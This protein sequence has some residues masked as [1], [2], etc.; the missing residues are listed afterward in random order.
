MDIVRQ[1]V[2]SELLIAIILTS[3]LITCI[4]L[5]LYNWFYLLKTLHSN[6]QIGVNP[7]E[8]IDRLVKLTLY[9]TLFTMLLT[10]VYL[11]L[12]IF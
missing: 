11:T 7:P 2:E 1:V 6:V 10:L 4:L 3:I 5:V 12:Q 8:Y 9:L